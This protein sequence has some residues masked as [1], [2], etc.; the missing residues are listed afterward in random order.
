VIRATADVSA[1]S[2]FVAIWRQTHAP[3]SS[4]PLVIPYRRVFPSTGFKRAV[5]R[6][7]AVSASFE[8]HSGD[9]VHRVSIRSGTGVPPALM[10]SDTTHPPVALGS[11][12]VV[13]SASLFA[14]YGQSELLVA[15]R[16]FSGFMPTALRRPEVPNTLSELEMA[17]RSAPP[18][19]GRF[20]YRCDNEF[21]ERSLH[22]SC[23]GSATAWSPASGYGGGLFNEAAAIRL[24][25]RPASCFPR[26]DGNFTTE[27][28]A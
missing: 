11:P 1:L 21:H 2:S 16:R 17:C 4:T 27:L 7:L 18:Y 23:R 6:A 20:S 12:T 8:R 10:A 24:M 14:Y 22:P 28:F 19:S 13:L 25:L 26:P 3:V 9:L 5:K 15:S